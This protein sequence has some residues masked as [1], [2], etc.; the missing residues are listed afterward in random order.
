M[1]IGRY[2]NHQT[3]RERENKREREG[4]RQRVRENATGEREGKRDVNDLFSDVSG[5]LEVAGP[6]A[7]PISWVRVSGLATRGGWVQKC[8]VVTRWARI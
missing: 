5:F 2:S 4:E 6:G 8:A 7:V 3:D 1:L